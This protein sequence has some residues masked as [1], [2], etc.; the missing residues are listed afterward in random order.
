MTLAVAVAPLETLDRKRRCVYSR[1]GGVDGDS[2]G[3]VATAPASVPVE[4]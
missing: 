1:A 2:E 4:M 3:A